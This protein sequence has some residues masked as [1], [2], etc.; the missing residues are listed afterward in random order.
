MSLD[1]IKVA[2]KKKGKEV[3]F[4]LVSFLVILL[5]VVILY[6]VI[7]TPV[8]EFSQNII[9]TFIFAII[10]I[11]PFYSLL[12]LYRTIKS[13][14]TIATL[15]Q[16]FV[17][18]AFSLGFLIFIFVS[19]YILVA[20]NRDLDKIPSNIFCFIVMLVYI[21]TQHIFIIRKYRNL[22]E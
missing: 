11:S 18:V 14:E 16:L 2:D 4:F 9:K 6:A 3:R 12:I 15:K 10:T 19:D 22:N 21:I 7:K 8:T 13:K 5:Q 20:T 1:I 17:F